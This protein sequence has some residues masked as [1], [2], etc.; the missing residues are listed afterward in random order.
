[1]AR[2][3]IHLD[4]TTYQLTIDEHTA[5]VDALIEM[6]LIPDGIGN[7][8]APQTL[9]DGKLD[10]DIPFVVIN[11]QFP[12]VG[13]IGRTI[14]LASPIGDRRRARDAEVCVSS[15]MYTIKNHLNSNS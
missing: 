10:L 1:V 8:K 12:F 15:S 4:R 13:S 7:R 6:V 11:E 2:K 14:P 9:V 5:V 3:I